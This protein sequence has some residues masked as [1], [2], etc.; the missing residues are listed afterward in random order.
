MLRYLVS[1]EDE[2]GYVHS[3]DKL[4]VV[5]VFGTKSN[6]T[7]RFLN[8][9]LKAVLDL[10]EGYGITP[11]VKSSLS[12]MSCY[13]WTLHFVKMRFGLPI[14]I[15]FQNKGK[16]GS[17][18]LKNTVRI[19]FNPNKV[20]EEDKILDDLI[21][22]FNS[23]CTDRYVSRLDYAIDIPVPLEDL[24]VLQSRKTKREYKGT[25][26]LGKRMSHGA[27]KI[28]DKQAEQNLEKP[29]TRFEITCRKDFKIKF[30][31][32]MVMRG[33]KMQSE[34][35]MTSNTKTIV[36]MCL[37]LKEAGYDYSDFIKGLNSRK[38][39]EVVYYVEGIGQTLLFD[40]VIFE[41]LYTE[42]VEK[43]KLGISQEELSRDMLDCFV[44]VDPDDIPFLVGDE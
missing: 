40:D 36:K 39:K 14:F 23:C 18:E 32:V 15:G 3:I 20:Y 16:D 25:I 21:R 1:L 29:L 9:L 10:A 13:A 2:F 11:E 8:E 35:K 41:T 34:E 5:W 31:N 24:V 38:R 33:D 44:D 28:Y 17:I 30:D 26:Y 4:S 27:I 43:L 19:E 37:A 7:D 22:L 6:F 12:P 42:L